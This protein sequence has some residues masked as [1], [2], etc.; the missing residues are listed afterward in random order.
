MK[1]IRIEEEHRFGLDA[2]I[3]RIVSEINE[4][5]RNSMKKLK[6]HVGKH[7][8]YIKT[9]DENGNEV[10]AGVP[11]RSLTFDVTARDRNR[12]TLVIDALDFEI[13]SDDTWKD[14]QA[15]EEPR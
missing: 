9:T 12:V 6:I 15:S 10:F 4:R 7:G 11:I 13:V 14:G 2:C 3:D 8:E 1:R 5:T